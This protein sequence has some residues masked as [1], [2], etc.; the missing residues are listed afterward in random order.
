MCL[1]SVY[2]W[3]R[4]FFFFEYK[5]SELK[6]IY[7]NVHMKK[8]NKYFKYLSNHLSSI[9]LTLALLLESLHLL[10]MKIANYRAIATIGWLLVQKFNTAI[11]SVASLCH[12]LSRIDTKN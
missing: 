6:F 1:T 5:E 10:V 11:Y 7:I 4:F 3:L 12:Q 9:H 8:L 2:S